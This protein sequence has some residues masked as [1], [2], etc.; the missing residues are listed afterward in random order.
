MALAP[1]QV[2]E[3][4]QARPGASRDAR[5]L[6]K[7]NS[8]RL[9]CLRLGQA[10]SKVAVVMEVGPPRGRWAMKWNRDPLQLSGAV[11]APLT[12]TSGPFFLQPRGL[13]RQGSLLPVPCSWGQTA[14]HRDRSVSLSVWPVLQSLPQ[15]AEGIRQFSA[16]TSTARS[17]TLASVGSL[18][19]TQRLPFPGLIFFRTFVRNFKLDQSSQNIFF[20]MFIEK[21]HTRSKTKHLAKTLSHICR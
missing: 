19:H 15:L 6:G 7:G 5:Y 18:V 20:V 14:P 13:S 17:Y 21:C 12:A 4:L 8:G 1:G 3:G 10:P 11:T 16:V 2:P 9:G